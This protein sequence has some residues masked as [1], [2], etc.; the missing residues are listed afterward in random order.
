M[1]SKTELYNS[2][3]DLYSELYER[4]DKDLSSLPDKPE[5]DT[6]STLRALW[7]KAA[8]EAKSAQSAAQSESLPS[9]DQ[10]QI[11]LLQSYVDKRLSGVPLP[12]ITE[13]QQFLNIEFIVGS[14]ALI[15]RKE[16]E[17]LGTSVL[18]RI[19]EMSVEQDQVLVVDVCTGAG[20]L[21]LAYAAYGPKVRVYAADIS[22]DA[23]NLAKKNSEYLDVSDRVSFDTGDLLSPYDNHEFYNKVDVLSCNPPYISSG[24]VEEMDAEISDFEPRLAFDGGPFGIKILQRLLKEAPK[25]LKDG[26]W[27]AFE[28]GAGQGQAI[29]KRLEKSGSYKNIES[30]KDE[31]GEIRAIL[32]QV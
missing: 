31:S 3:T 10:D 16:T 17:L 20:N 18:R 15:P 5:E 2:K 24:K 26:G 21:A 22:A 7:F 19:E 14:E 13:R 11:E 27:L 1:N 30:I 32:A 9:L 25:Y 23:V 29:I 4:L 6:H 12:H 8:G 28:V